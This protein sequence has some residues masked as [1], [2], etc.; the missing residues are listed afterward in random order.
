MSFG[1][2]FPF[3][4]GLLC[5]NVVFLVPFRTL[6]ATP[7]VV[8]VSDLVFDEAFGGVL[9]DLGGDLGVLRGGVDARLAC[10]DELY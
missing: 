8:T 9:G 10:N 6:W 4:T 1:P 5:V 3:F 7:R 2:L